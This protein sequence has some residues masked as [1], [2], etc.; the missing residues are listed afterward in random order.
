MASATTIAV[1]ARALSLTLN[2]R[3]VAGELAVARAAAAIAGGRA[4]ALLAGGVDEMEPRVARALL[5]LGVLDQTHGEGA[6]FLVLEG[7]T[8]PGL[9]ARRL[10]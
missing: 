3:M 2:A 8:R 4:S 7:A 6:T 5:D 9:A 1:G 10:R